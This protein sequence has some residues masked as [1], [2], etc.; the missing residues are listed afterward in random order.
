PAH[1]DLTFAPGETS[2]T[3]VVDIRGDTLLEDTQYFKVVLSNVTTAIP[4]G[5]PATGSVNVQILNDD[6]PKLSVNS[7]VG[8]EGAIFLFKATL[9]QRYYQP[10]NVCYYTVDGTAKATDGDYTPISGCGAIIPAGSKAVALPAITANYDFT[11][12]GPETFQVVAVSVN[13]PG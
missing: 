4:S 7:H 11:S 3:V 12:E 1:G 10:V 8:V 2:K 5:A 9:T 13:I 6:L